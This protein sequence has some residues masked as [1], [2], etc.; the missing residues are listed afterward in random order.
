M[1]IPEASQLVIQAGAMATG[2]DVFVL[3]MGQPVKIKN[4]AERMIELSGLSVKNE[5][6]LDGDIEIE[7]TK[8]RPGEKLYEELLIG[9]NPELTSHNRIMKAHEPFLKWD[10]LEDEIKTLIVA[11]NAN[12]VS[13]V[14]H[15]L[16]KLVTDYQPNKDIVDWVYLEHGQ[17][18]AMH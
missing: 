1:T 6:N 9:N 7:V 14:R 10:K 15:L 18:G 12:D 5:Q 2:G 11:L 3:D 13:L 8:L 16:Q 4:L 17:K